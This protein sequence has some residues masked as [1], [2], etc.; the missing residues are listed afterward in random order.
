MSAT[1]PFLADDYPD[2][3][4]QA[5]Q[6]AGE[7]PVVADLKAPAAA[8][9]LL[10]Q[11]TDFTQGSLS[12][13]KGFAD[14]ATVVAGN[15]AAA[16]IADGLFIGVDANVA[17]R[18]VALPSAAAL[19][20]GFNFIVQKVDSSPNTI[21]ITPDGLETINGSNSPVVLGQQGG[22]MMLVRVSATQWLAVSPANFT[23]TPLSV[24]LV[25]AGQGV[26]VVPTAFTAFN[27]LLSQYMALVNKEARTLRAGTD[28]MDVALTPTTIGK[29]S[30]VTI[31]AN[32]EID[33]LVGPS[34]F[35]DEFYLEVIQG[36]AGGFT[37]TWGTGVSATSVADVAP[38][39][40]ANPGDTTLCA[41][42]RMANSAVWVMTAAR[43]I[44]K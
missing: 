43:E 17:P 28:T 30:N 8:N 36:G 18:A 15:V 4:S 23:G 11:W 26:V 38:S 39:F 34:V 3:F 32:I 14:N 37:P 2:I 44:V 27:T 29:Y 5:L 19:R 42:Q 13:Q 35:G 22:A 21:T 31:G 40:G 10:R 9:L 16:A 24:A 25:A 7:I 33:V 20:Q 6:A 41:F 1:D 12:G